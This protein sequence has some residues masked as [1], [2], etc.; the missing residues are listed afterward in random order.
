MASKTVL[1]KNVNIPIHTTDL[2]TFDD[3]YS[4]MKEKFQAE[5]RKISIEMDKFSSD[6]SRLYGSPAINSS[7]S[8]PQNASVTSPQ[9]TSV[10]S[11]NTSLTS[12]KKLAA[13]KKGAGKKKK[14][15]DEAGVRSPEPTVVES[16]QTGQTLESVG[17][18]AQDKAL[19]AD[20]ANWAAITESPLIL[21]EGESK[22]LKLQFDVS[23]F[24]PA[25]VKVQII[26][27]VLHVKAKHDERTDNILVLREYNRQFLLPRGIDP[28]AVV[29]SLSRDGVLTVEAPLPQLVLELG[30]ELEKMKTDKQ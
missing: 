3:S 12:Q 22:K 20:Q 18:S 24:D 16:M 19:A 14:G 13:Q 1:Q 30:K 7:T 4:F 9:D 28:E 25:E 6:L 2:S 21:E 23:Q 15:S 11:K 26:N 8:S 29:S 10:T 27:D 5:M 17:A